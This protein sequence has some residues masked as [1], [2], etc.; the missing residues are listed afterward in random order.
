MSDVKVDTQTKARK[1]AQSLKA[2]EEALEALLQADPPHAINPC[3][4]EH[5]QIAG[6]KL[7]HLI[8]ATRRFPMFDPACLSRM[9]EHTIKL[10]DGK[11]ATL[12]LP[13][14]AW[15]GWYDAQNGGKRTIEL[16]FREVAFGERSIIFDPTKIL[17][18]EQGLGQRQDR[19]DPLTA[20][21]PKVPASV[22]SRVDAIPPI[23]DSIHVV[24]EAEWVPSVAKDPLVIGQVGGHCFLIDQWD[25]TSL[26]RYVSNEFCVNP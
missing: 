2:A 23:F 1:T 11:P 20:R 13:L 25:M 5:L 24:Y 15:V 10:Q 12:W 18:N 16:R 22:A 6:N 14:F 19:W 8:A 26:E 9:S 4:P 21:C 17:F 3:A 7:L